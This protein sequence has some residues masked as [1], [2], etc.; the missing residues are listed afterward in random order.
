MSC[1]YYID[2]LMTLKKKIPIRDVLNTTHASCEKAKLHLT[3]LEV[4]KRLSLA[5]FINK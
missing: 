1:E 5:A 2:G 4:V 3:K